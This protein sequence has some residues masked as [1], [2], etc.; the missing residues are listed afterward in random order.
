MSILKTLSSSLEQRYNVTNVETFFVNE[1]DD[2]LT[3]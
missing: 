1:E 2:C 3:F